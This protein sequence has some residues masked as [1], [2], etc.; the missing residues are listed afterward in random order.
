MRK[1]RHLEIAIELDQTIT[2]TRRSPAAR[3]WCPA[4][5]SKVIMVTLED[6]V[7]LTSIGVLAM[8]RMVK[9]HQLHF[10]ETSSGLINLCLPSL[11]QAAAA[12]TST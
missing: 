2:I 3:A 12:T 5:R 4:C 9:A 8:V 6:G 1:N 11:L 7:T 10:T